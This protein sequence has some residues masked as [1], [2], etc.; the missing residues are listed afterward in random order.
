M[1]CGIGKQSGI[2]RIPVNRPVKLRLNSEDVIHGFYIPA[3]RIKE[4]CVPNMGTYLSFTANMT[5]TYD[6]FCTEYCGHG[7]SGMVSKV[8]VMADN[9]F[10]AWYTAVTDEERKLE[11]KT[12]EKILEAYDCLDCH[13]TDGKTM[14]GPTFKGLDPE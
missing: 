9:D 12:G 7:H 11:M 5:G 8:E 3:F 14:D 1:R 13:T 4:D 6:I 10:D 2:L